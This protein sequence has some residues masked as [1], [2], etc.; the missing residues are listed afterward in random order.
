M[1]PSAEMSGVDLNG[2]QDRMKSVL[3]SKSIEK[4][5][6]QTTSSAKLYSQDDPWWADAA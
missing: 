5:Y 4:T 3:A 2:S 1:S 6:K